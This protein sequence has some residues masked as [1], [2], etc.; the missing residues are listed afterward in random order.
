MQVFVRILKYFA[1]II[2]DSCIFNFR[3][4]IKFVHVFCLLSTYKL[5]QAAPNKS[6]AESSKTG[7]SLSNFGAKRS[8][9][10]LKSIKN[11]SLDSSMCVCCLSY[12]IMIY[13]ICLD[14]YTF[15]CKFF[16]FYITYFKQRGLSMNKRKR[17]VFI[18]LGI[19]ILLTSVIIYDSG[20]INLFFRAPEDGA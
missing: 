20:V 7:T 8:K 12:E 11:R 2:F 3:I 16:L 18:L 4:F 5:H 15:Q 17:T 13:Y 6:R 19:I 1:G 10:E 14:V 9:N